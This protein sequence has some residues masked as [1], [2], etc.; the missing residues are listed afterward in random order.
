MRKSIL[1][2]FLIQSVFL[3]Q[4]KK[5]IEKYIDKTIK[6]DSLNVPL[7]KNQ[8][9]FPK[10]MFPN[11]DSIQYIQQKDSS[12]IAKRV[13]SKDK[14][15]DSVMEWYSEYL[16]G[17]KEPLLFNRKIDN[18]IFRF[19]WLRSFDE[20]IV[21]R[22]TETEQKYHLNWKK[23]KLNENHKP[24]EIILDESKSI[25]KNEWE[26]FNELVRKADFWNMRLGRYS[27]DTDGSE[28]ILEG[29]NSENYRVVSVFYPEKG[30][31]YNACNYLISLTNLKISEK[32]KY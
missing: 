22:I 21:I 31:F 14:Y 15:D 19:T 12:Y 1:F 4:C 10:E 8:F 3:F 2:I 13:Y 20:P 23:L 17:M 11:I 16:F 18:A 29:V 7:D 5:S 28:W 9:Y 26:S 24:I 25:T 6:V 27:I 32:Y 30:D